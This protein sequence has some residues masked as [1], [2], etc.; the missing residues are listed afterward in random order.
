VHEQIERG[1]LKRI[2]LADVKPLEVGI[3]A[4]FPTR[5]QMPARVRRFIDA[6]R[7]RLLVAADAA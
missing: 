4:V 2:V 5:T 6:L 1:E 3:W 7:E